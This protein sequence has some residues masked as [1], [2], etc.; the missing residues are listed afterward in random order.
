MR[1]FYVWSCSACFEALWAMLEAQAYQWQDELDENA[2]TTLN[3]NYFGHHDS[4]S[5]R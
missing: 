5:P 1:V 2:P 4:P 3:P